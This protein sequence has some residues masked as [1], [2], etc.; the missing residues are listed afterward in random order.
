MMLFFLSLTAIAQASLYIDL[1]YLIMFFSSKGKLEFFKFLPHH[2][3]R[4]PLSDCNPRDKNSNK[5]NYVMC[6]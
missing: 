3:S 1:Q 6:G 4:P 5:E 2:Y